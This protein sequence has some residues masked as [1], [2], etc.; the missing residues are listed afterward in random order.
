MQKQ[1]KP[2][3]RIPFFDR[4]AETWDD[5]HTL[6]QM[7]GPLGAAVDTWDLNE[8]ETVLD[9]GC[10]T[11]NLTAVLLARL[12]KA[13]R[14]VG[15]DISSAMLRRA[16]LKIDDPRVTWLLGAADRIDLPNAS[17]DRVICFSV[18]PHFA[19]PIAV[20]KELRRVLR[21]HGQVHVLHLISR[22]AVNHIHRAAHETVQ[23]DLL[24]PV[25]EIAAIFRNEGFD[26]L[27]AEED[28]TRYLLTARL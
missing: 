21:P 1:S 15:L 8:N 28:E 14:V 11:G 4:L 24:A 17:C 22:E 25:N 13:G 2:D 18:W 23:Q 6:E 27:I 10:G 9:V 20:L 7:M 3:P 5:A 12:G 19:D 26:V 16:R